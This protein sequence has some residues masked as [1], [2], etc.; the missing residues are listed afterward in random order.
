ME[1]SC[2]RHF[3]R[4]VYLS[5]WDGLAGLELCSSRYNCDLANPL[6]VSS[7][8]PF[9]P[10]QL[11]GSFHSSPNK[12]NDKY[13]V[14]KSGGRYGIGGSETIVFKKKTGSNK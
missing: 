8:T 9:R 6:Q 10:I 12:L 3:N 4:F 7:S 2:A 14:G 13:L 5:V 1:S 11:A